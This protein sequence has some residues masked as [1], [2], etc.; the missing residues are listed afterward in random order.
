ML[1]SVARTGQLHSISIQQS[2]FSI[3]SVTLRPR[4][5]PSLATVPLECSMN[6]LAQSNRGS[7]A[8]LGACATDIERAALGKKID[9]AAVDRRLDPKRTADRF[10]QRAG[11]PDRPDRQGDARGGDA[12]L[13]GDQLPQTIQRR[14]FVSRQDVGPSRPPGPPR[15]EKESREKIV[16]V[17]QVIED[18]AR[19]KNDEPSSRDASKQLQQTAIAGAVNA[20]GSRD[21]HFHAGVA[22]GGPGGGLPFELRLLI[23]VTGPKRRI[24]ICGWMLDIT[25]N[26]DGAAMHDAFRT[27]R[28]CG[29]DHRPDRVGIDGPVLLFTETGLTI[30]GGDVIDDLYSGR[31]AAD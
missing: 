25:V 27:A 24:F 9:A 3:L 6:T 4:S 13:R 2:K 7:I 1:G 15:T 14:H 16:D 5:Q 17:R 12:R 18:L 30:D 28:L 23:D 31:C 10:A 22:S 26:A 29:F 11:R 21:H 8:K 20:G 19:A